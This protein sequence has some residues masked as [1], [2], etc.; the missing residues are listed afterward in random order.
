MA[1]KIAFITRKENRVLNGFLEK[2]DSLLELCN[3][4]W[5]DELIDKYRSK[6]DIS[7][8]GKLP[9]IIFQGYPL[10]GVGEV[11]SRLA[12]NFV[13]NRKYIVDLDHIGEKEDDHQ[14]PEKIF[15]FILS[16]NDFA[17]WNIDM[18]FITPSGK[19]LKIIAEMTDPNDT[20][21]EAQRKFADHF[22]LG[23]WYD[24]VNIDYSRLAFIPKRSEI[25]YLQ[26]SLFSLLKPNLVA[27]MEDIDKAHHEL[28]ADGEKNAPAQKPAPSGRAS[29]TPEDFSSYESYQF[30]GRELKKIVE[31]WTTY[32]GEQ[33]GIIVNGKPFAGEVHSLHYNILRDIRSLCESNPALMTAMVPTFGHDTTEIYNQAKKVCSYNTNGRIPSNV[34]HW[35]KEKGYLSQSAE[36]EEDEDVDDELESPYSQLLAKMPELPP[37]I[38]D[39]VRVAPYEF[40]VPTIAA[41]LEILGTCTTYAQADYFDGTPHTTSFFT[42]VWAEAAGGKSFV[43]RFLYLHDLI[44]NREEIINARE[45]LYD[46][47][48]SSK[49]DN[50]D[51]PEKPILCKRILEPKF[52]EVQLFTQCHENH[53]T[54]LHTYCPEIDTLGRG[55][56]GLSD[57]LRMAWDNDATGQQFRSSNTFKGTVKLYWNL[58]ATGTP[59]RVLAFFRDVLDGLITRISILPIF[60][61]EFAPYRA[62]GK[63]SPKVLD[64][65][66]KL[67]EMFDEN[68]Y[69]DPVDQ[70]TTDAL[71]EYKDLDMFDK[72]VNWK[73]RVRPRISRDLSY[74]HKPLLKWLNEIRKKTSKDVNHAAYTF[75]KRSANKGFRAGLVANELWN[76]PQTE[77][78]QKKV[79]DFALW[80][81]EVEYF[82]TNYVFGEEYNKRRTEA[83]KQMGG[84]KAIRYGGAFEQ[85]P[86]EFTKGELIAICKK[87]AIATEPRAIV[88]VWLVEGLIVKTSKNQWKKK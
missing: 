21:I 17:D 18:V 68:T 58:L 85:L 5:I 54:H 78:M 44:R 71:S 69:E 77:K 26:E 47:F 32:R 40:K 43:K 48:V 9:A 55:V 6:E 88:S 14:T 87:L 29:T 60:N 16:F 46:A 22:C 39:W 34:Y 56:R 72:N 19:G 67:I 1:L 86:A 82:A 27:L 81:T 41:L 73:F 11:G 76:N 62:W 61:T 36:D 3:Q 74:L 35:L 83:R 30:R 49:S 75:S 45:R 10:K 2:T 70:F 84:M 52:S 79:L 8:K 53:G 38:K 25:L 12:Q 24:E 23:R 20:I 80:W 4:P 7:A 13:S 51:A 33:L 57:L 28:P 59:E 37:I 64:G 63:I 50:K 66:Y 42:V 31:E 65:H 15:N